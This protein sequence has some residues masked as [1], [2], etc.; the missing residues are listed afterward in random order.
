MLIQPVLNLRLNFDPFYLGYN[1][2]P[3]N[4]LTTLHRTYGIDVKDAKTYRNEV[5]GSI[6]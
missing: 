1:E 2:D 3:D 4:V 5:S 6:L